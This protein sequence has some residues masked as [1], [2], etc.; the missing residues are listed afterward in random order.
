MSASNS[1]PGRGCRRT[2]R[3][4]ARTRSARARSARASGSSSFVS[5]RT[6]RTLV[7]AHDQRQRQDRQDALRQ[8]HQGTDRSARTAAWRPSRCASGCG[9]ADG[10]RL[11]RQARSTTP[12]RRAKS[13]RNDPAPLNRRKRPQQRVTT[14]SPAAISASE[15]ARRSTTLPDDAKKI[16]AW[17]EPSSARRVALCTRDGRTRRRH[18]AGRSFASLGSTARRE[19]NRTRDGGVRLESQAEVA[20]PSVG[21]GDL[22]EAIIGGRSPGPVHGV[23]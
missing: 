18:S 3:V 8:A 23:V 13:K 4:R 5:A 11:H 10:P 7:S 15:I 1:S 2:P 9:A 16:A 6:T 12:A 21:L 19:P 17:D 20:D 14:V 22:G